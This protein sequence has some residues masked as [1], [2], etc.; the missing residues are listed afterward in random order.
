MKKIRQLL[1]VRPGQLEQVWSYVE[2][3]LL[4]SKET[5]ERYYS[6]EDIGVGILSHKFQLWCMND[7]T[8]ILLAAISEIRQFPKCRVMHV[9]W[10]CGEELDDA[11][12]FLSCIEMWGRNNGA[13]ESLIQGR[14][15]W[16]K[17][18]KP[19]GY[20]PEQIV[21]RKSLETLR[22]N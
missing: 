2:P 1:C 20:D 8:V 15:G 18:L 5:W 4:Q 7:E 14:L 13:T 19:F 16:T 10:I 9:S 22:S 3:L 11:L 6:L 21:L 12:E 17:V